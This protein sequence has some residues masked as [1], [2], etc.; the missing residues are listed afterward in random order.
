VN[1]SLFHHVFFEY[2][3]ARPDELDDPHRDSMTAEDAEKWLAEWSEMGGRSD[4]FVVVRR[5]VGDWAQVTGG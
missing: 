1:P 4:T 5:P 3:V 2:G